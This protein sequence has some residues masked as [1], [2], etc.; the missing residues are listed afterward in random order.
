VNTL[1]TI[2]DIIMT[3]SGV[4]PSGINK[5]TSAESKLKIN[6]MLVL[7]DAKSQMD[8][9]FKLIDFTRNSFVPELMSKTQTDQTR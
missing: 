7:F 9:G 3:F 6:L 4:L 8:E 2:T 1:S 5:T